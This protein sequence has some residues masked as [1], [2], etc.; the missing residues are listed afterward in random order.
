MN[1][2]IARKRISQVFMVDSI[3]SSEAD[4][5]ATHIPFRNITFRHG[6]KDIGIEPY[7]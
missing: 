5:M 1:I 6:V 7:L 3:N 2:D 4:F